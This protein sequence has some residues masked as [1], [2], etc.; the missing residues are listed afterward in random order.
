MID[1]DDSITVSN[2]VS[3][4]LQIGHAAGGNIN[5]YYL[6]S[7]GYLGNY[8]SLPWFVAFNAWYWRAD[9]VVL[10]HDGEA[11]VN[12]YSYLPDNTMH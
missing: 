4:I 11:G 12:Q 3:I 5:I 9:C 8:F 2:V 10:I 1:A 7:S 6:A